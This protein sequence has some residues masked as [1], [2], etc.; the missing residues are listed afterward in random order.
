MTA[1]EEIQA[2]RAEAFAVARDIVTEWRAS[3]R[4]STTAGITSKMK[5]LGMLNLEMLGLAANKE[6]WEHATASGL[7]KVEQQ[8]NGHWFVLLPGEQLSDFDVQLKPEAEPA[9]LAH[10]LE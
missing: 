9:S 5:Q 10:D 7:V 1:S 6:F 8:A 3:G 4:R 2:R